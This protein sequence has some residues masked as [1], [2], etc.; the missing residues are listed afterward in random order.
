MC[1]VF[2]TPLWHPVFISMIS[3]LYGFEFMQI[4][5]LSTKSSRNDKHFISWL[6]HMSDLTWHMTRDH[7]D[8]ALGHQLSMSNAPKF[9]SWYTY[10]VTNILINTRGSLYQGDWRFW[11]LGFKDEHKLEQCCFLDWVFEEDMMNMLRYIRHGVGRVGQ[12]N[13]YIAT[14][15]VCKEHRKWITFIAIFKKLHE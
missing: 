2:R 1:C 9:I 7:A 14:N 10:I 3:N 11:N 4:Q 5:V 12:L 8:L 6:L 15:W 13:V